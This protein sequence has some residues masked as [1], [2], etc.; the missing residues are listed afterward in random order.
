MGKTVYFDC[1]SGASG[2]MVIGALLDLGLP[3]DDLRAA[4]GSLAIEYG[5][6]SSERVLR[7]GVSATKFRV[8]AEEGAAGSAADAHYV[9]FALHPPQAGHAHD[10][11]HPH[12]HSHS[13]EHSHPH[14]HH[15]HVAAQ[16][17]VHSH[18]VEGR[19]P[20]GS[21]PGVRAPRGTVP[22]GAPSQSR[23]PQFE[24]NRGIHR[25]VSSLG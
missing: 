21:G 22:S 10:G 15:M 4:L 3:L 23:T 17:A 12:S 14:E 1:F 20:A 25:S 9:A 11:S 8:H 19:H 13:A 6:V 24:G 2:D 7:A 5:G 16:T 18:E